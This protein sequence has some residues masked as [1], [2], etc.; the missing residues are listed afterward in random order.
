ML[1]TQNAS[2]TPPPSPPHWQVNKKLVQDHTATAQ[3]S[4][5]QSLGFLITTPVLYSYSN[6]V[7]S[8]FKSLSSILK[9][10]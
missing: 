4:Q 3:L 5:G 2:I 8:G 6:N 9:Q 7:H 1:R 10:Y